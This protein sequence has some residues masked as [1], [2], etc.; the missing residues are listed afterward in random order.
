M[1]KIK[2]KGSGW[3]IKLALLVYKLFGYRSIFYLLYPIT[4]FYFLFL[5]DTKEPLKKYY[6]HLNIRLTNRVYYEHLRQFSIAFLDRFATRIDKSIFT[7]E[8]EEYEELV[9]LFKG[10]IVLIQSHFGGWA[11]S[12][13][14]PELKNKIHIVMQESMLESI[15]I[16]ENSIKTKTEISVID[17]NQNSIITSIQIA[18]ALMNDEVVA[19]MGDRAI[20]YKSTI[21]CEFLGAQANFNKNPFEIAY[22]T[23]KPVVLFFI[24]FISQ[25]RYKVKFIKINM[26]RNLKQIDSVKNAI[27]VYAKEYEKILRT[28]PNQWFN[29]YDFWSK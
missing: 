15:K 10:G 16:L 19:T 9:E 17:L 29:F 25:R 12:S 26:D 20:N 18:N 22:K 28:Y 7:Y 4:F 23:N 14:I 11:G 6:K 8:H 21:R 13:N 1:I 24:I 2:Q 3:S 5:K 27:H